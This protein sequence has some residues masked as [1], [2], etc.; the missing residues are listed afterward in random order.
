MNYCS[1]CGTEVEGDE[2][3][4]PE[5]GTKINEPTTNEKSGQDGESKEDD[6][7]LGIS[8]DETNHA[9]AL[10]FAAIWIIFGFVLFVETVI[11]GIL[12][13]AAGLIT[14]RRVRNRLGWEIPTAGIA[15]ILILSMAGAGMMIPSENVGTDTE[16]SD[17]VNEPDTDGDGG[18]TGN[19][20]SA[21]TDAVTHEIGETFT[22]GSGDRSVE[23][24]VEEAT[25]ADS[26]G[27]S[28]ASSEADGTF[29]VVRLTI[30][31]SG[32]EPFMVTN[33][34]LSLIDEEGRTF[35][36]ATGA[37]VYMSQDDR[38]EAESLSFEELQP[39]LSITRNVI[40]DVS[41]GQGYG[42]RVEGTSMFSTAD[43]HYV[44]LGQAG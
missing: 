22:V 37:G 11:G 35:S 30:E 5:C 34:H 9:I 10:F 33:D 38:F 29:V 32:T 6:E 44:P 15:V 31:N 21:S 42:L 36:A 39:G 17:T 20:Q 26:I 25:T 40:Y 24:T 14:T 1:E 23:Y 19:G 16:P 4:C 12:M 3:Y 2:T 8:H 28:F 41:S 27:T 43:P 18:G 13:I 7:T